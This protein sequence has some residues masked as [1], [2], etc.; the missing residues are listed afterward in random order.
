MAG[1]RKAARL[2]E[3]N[4]ILRDPDYLACL[5]EN[6]R[7]EAGRVF[8]RH[9]P[10]HM[11]DVARL[12]YILL[13]ESGQLAIVARERGRELVYAAGL[14][15]D[16]GRWRQYDGNGDHAPAGAELAGPI[17]LRAGFSPAEVELV[18]RAIAE[19]RLSSEGTSILGRV[20]ARA[21]DLSRAC[22]QCRVR[23]NCYKADRME[24][25]AGMLR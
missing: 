2:E 19:H 21:D 23:E 18:G 8:C 25:A 7:R 12:A 6:A 15:H 17:L 1:R 11:L 4:R 16:I 9:G 3:I 10:Q 13:L 5:R 24:T 14:L 20:L 22:W